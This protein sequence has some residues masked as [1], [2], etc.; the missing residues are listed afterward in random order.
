MSQRDR[1]LDPSAPA[2]RGREST[3]LTGI[4]F[5]TGRDPNL[6]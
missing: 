1:V 6:G 2:D 4:E 3:F 5:L